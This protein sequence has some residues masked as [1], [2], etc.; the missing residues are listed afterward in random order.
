MRLLSN[1]LW[2]DTV[3]ALSSCG[4]DTSGDSAYTSENL[5]EDPLVVLKCDPRVFR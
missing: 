4:S 1:R 3:N 2:V 5:V